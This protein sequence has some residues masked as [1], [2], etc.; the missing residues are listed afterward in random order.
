MKGNIRKRLVKTLKQI[1]TN[2]QRNSN[3][4]NQELLLESKPLSVAIWKDDNVFYLFDSKPR[5]KN[6]FAVN[7]EQWLEPSELD[8]A[9]IR[10]SLA[11]V[12]SAAPIEQETTG[13]E[14]TAEEEGLEFQRPTQ[15]KGV[16]LT[17]EGND[18][19]LDDEQEIGNRFNEGEGARVQIFGGEQEEEGRGGDE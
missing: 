11:I 16:R 10:L 19:E 6:G 1:L 3:F 7:I 5:D 9:K 13:E 18:D 4:P 12:E 2:P 14:V 15:K 8:G 17:I